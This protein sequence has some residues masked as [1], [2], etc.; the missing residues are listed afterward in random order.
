MIWQKSGYEKST[1]SWIL[2]YFFKENQ[3][4]HSLWIFC[5]TFFKLRPN[6][7]GSKVSLWTNIGEIRSPLVLSSILLTNMFALVLQD[8]QAIFGNET[9]TVSNT[10]KQILFLS[11]NN[12]KICWTLR[13][14]LWIVEVLSTV[15][16]W[17]SERQWYPSS[18]QQLQKW[19]THH[20]LGSCNICCFVHS[21]CSVEEWRNNF[22]LGDPWHEITELVWANI[23]DYTTNWVHGL[24]G[25]IIEVG[26]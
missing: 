23:Q 1:T 14:N 4:L 10:P 24:G 26:R 3:T 22:L 6:Q 19:Q 8:F 25:I 9:E 18:T 21:T 2:L 5:S 13:I 12:S 16:V 7:S 17:I 11:L 15:I 20:F